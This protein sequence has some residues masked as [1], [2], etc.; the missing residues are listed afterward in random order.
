LAEA[1]D[2]RAFDLVERAE[3][4]DD[5]A[6]HVARGPD[7][8]DLDLPARVEARLD[9]FGEIAEVAV[10]EAEA[11]G[12]AARRTG[13]PVRHRHRLLDHALGARRAEAGRRHS[14]ETLAVGERLAI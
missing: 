5:V 1:V 13:G 7:I 12:A 8:V 14:A 11:L 2:D 3:R 4:V 6:A 9:H 10:I